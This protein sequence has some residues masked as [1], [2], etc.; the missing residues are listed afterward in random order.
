MTEPPVLVLHL[1]SA[2]ARARILNRLKAQRRPDGTEVYLGSYNINPDDIEALK[3]EAIPN[4]HYAPT[5]HLAANE[6]LDLKAARPRPPRGSPLLSKELDGPIPMHPQHTRIAS[7][8]PHAWGVELGRRF[9]DTLRNAENKHKVKLHW[10]LDEIPPECGTSK[11]ARLFVGGVIL[12]LAKGRPK[13][14][15]KLKPGFVWVAAQALDKLPGLPITISDV[16][17]F[18]QDVDTGT[19]YLVGEEYPEFVG[20]AGAVGQKQAKPQR[21]LRASG[22]AH[23]QALA[24]RYILGMTPGFH[25][26]FDGGLHG[27]VKHL[28]PKDVTAW[29]KRF[30]VAR[31]KAEKPCGYGMFSFDG[32][33]NTVQANIDNAITALHFAAGRHASP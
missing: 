6:N 30:I 5:F 9:R 24:R 20:D 12:G 8:N 16:K 13:L 4:V 1:Y 7:K 23:C 3:K 26:P 33:F 27:N 18:W 28:P 10:Q 31:C 11:D 22:D 21:A 2:K 17:L 29:R 19:K 25:E 15:D 32:K 14:G